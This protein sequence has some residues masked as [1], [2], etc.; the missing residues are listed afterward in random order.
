[1]P[2]NTFDTFFSRPEKMSQDTWV[3]SMGSVFFVLYTYALCRV[4][5]NQ[6]EFYFSS[7][8]KMA[9]K[10]LGVAQDLPKKDVALNSSFKKLVLSEGSHEENFGGIPEKIPE[11]FH[12]DQRRKNGTST[13][14]DQILGT[15]WRFQATPPK[16]RPPGGSLQLSCSSLELRRYS[17]ASLG[18]T[19][20]SP[21]APIWDSW[22]GYIYLDLPTKMNHSYRY[23]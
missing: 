15:T 4:V 13:G 20:Q 8:V 7:I 6:R 18:S 12:S 2:I 1:M 23:I 10:I 21:K 19:F 9:G 22:D 5:S 17:F 16:R 14:F 11:G 3:P